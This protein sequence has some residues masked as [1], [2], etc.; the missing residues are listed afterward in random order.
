MYGQLQIGVAGGGILRIVL[1]LVLFLALSLLCSTSFAEGN[2]DAVSA[3]VSKA[4]DG[5]TDIVTLQNEVCRCDFIPLKSGVCSF[6]GVKDTGCSLTLQPNP[7]LLREVFTHAAMQLGG[8]DIPFQYQLLKDQPDRV[9][10]EFSTTLDI[11]NADEAV[12]GCRFSKRVTLYAGKRFLEVQQT[13]TNATGDVVGAQVGVRQRFFLDA[14]KDQDTFYLP[15]ERNILR[16]VA[17]GI[18]HFYAKM[19]DWEYHPVEAWMGAI[20]PKSGAGIVFVM[21]SGS[22]DGYYTHNASG[23]S[24]WFLDG[25]II[26]PGAA[27]TTAY[28]MIPVNGFQGLA[29]ASRRLIAD[30][31]AKAI[32]GGVEI[33]HTIAGSTAT[34]GNVLLKTSIMG[35]RSKKATS[36]PEVSAQNVGMDPIEAKVMLNEPQEEPLVIRVEAVGTNWKESYET[37]F[38]GE[39]K[40]TIYPGYPYTPEYRRPKRAQ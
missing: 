2:T 20:N 16:I 17:G 34:L 37:Y 24:G 12:A 3:S 25:G 33:T 26:E 29:H 14:V 8:K 36:L 35:A 31:Q 30:T 9:S 1:E 27:F 38:E 32:G 5:I 11:S 7:E 15:T 21:D 18:D 10:V 6:L 13:L 40:T 19:E 22:L 28:T 4:A 23:T 39:F